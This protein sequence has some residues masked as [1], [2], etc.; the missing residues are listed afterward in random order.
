MNE[1]CMCPETCL[2]RRI[3]T[4]GKLRWNLKIKCKGA[5]AAY[6]L[7]QAM[8]DWHDLSDEA[9]ERLSEIA[10]TGNRGRN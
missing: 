8:K 4:G 7:S 5:D 6:C 2:L 1:N 3:Y 10:A 9:R